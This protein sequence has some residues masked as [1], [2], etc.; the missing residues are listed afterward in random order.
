MK[1]VSIAIIVA[2]GL[3]LGVLEAGAQARAV[4]SNISGKVQIQ[5]PGET[6]WQAATEGMEVPVNATISTGFDGRAV[7]KLGAST[8][9]VRPL[10]RLRINELS[11]QNNVTKTSIAMPVGRIRAEVKSTDGTK[12][13]FTVHSALSTAAV[14]GTGFET[15]GVHLTVFES[16][17][18]FLS[19]SG[20]GI[21]VHNGETGISSGGDTPSGGA[22]QREHNT[23]VDTNP[24]GTG[25]GGLVGGL[26]GHGFGTITVK[27]Q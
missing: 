24:S 7:L 14:R 5:N 25:A 8:L 11:M 9:A 26:P 19:Q 21:N 13:D 27:Y 3:I 20:I 10:T 17:V 23:G 2:L 16:I 22:E 4:L 1:R 15:D 18:A 6:A 12:N